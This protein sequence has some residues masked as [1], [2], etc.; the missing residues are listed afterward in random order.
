MASPTGRMGWSFGLNW[1]VKRLLNFY[2]NMSIYN[3]V[4]FYEKSKF[5]LNIANKND[6]IIVNVEHNRV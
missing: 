1:N 5:L 2:K 3:K 6:N 4:D